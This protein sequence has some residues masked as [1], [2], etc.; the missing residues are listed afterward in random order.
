MKIF[1]YWQIEKETL[2]LDGEETVINVYGG[3]NLSDEDARRQAREKIEKIKQKISGARHVFEDYEVE[4]REEIV[5]ALDEKAIITR[6]RY[7]AQVLNLQEIMV[8]D[9][10][11]PQTSLMDIFRKPGPQADKQKIIE[12]V[13]KLAQKPPYNQYGLRLYETPKGIRVIV[14]G[15]T[16]DPSSPESDQMMKDFHCDALYRVLCKKQN[17]Y[18]ARLTPKPYRIKVPGHKVKIPRSAS[19]EAA[20]QSWL[21]LYEHKSQAFSACRFLEQIGPG[22][23][24]EAVRLHDD[25]SGA[26]RNLPLA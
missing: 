11:K 13:R 7:G 23:P 12:M 5:R 25:L 26:Y 24:G 14:V 1:K 3:S 10:D 2:S 20:F 16:F 4:I 8:L 15:R 17:C 22:Q 18:R 19:E 6:N 21:A 9:I